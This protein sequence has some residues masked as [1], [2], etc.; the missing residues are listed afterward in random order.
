MGAGVS[1]HRAFHLFG[2]P[3]AKKAVRGRPANSERVRFGI[4]GLDEVLGGGLSPNHLFLIDGDPGTG[5]TTIGMQ[6]LME[7]RDLGERVMYV[8]LSE[9]AAELKATAESH[10]WTLEGIDIFELTD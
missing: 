8:T 9:T 1:D 6:F 10:G 2:V 3:V 5:K 7:G 4:A